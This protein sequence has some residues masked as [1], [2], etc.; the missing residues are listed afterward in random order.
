VRILTLDEVS[1]CFGK[2]SLWAD[3]RFIV[4]KGPELHPC[5]N[6]KPCPTKRLPFPLEIAHFAPLESAAVVARILYI[7]SIEDE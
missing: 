1:A 3:E 2:T 7:L 6:W 4:R 5:K